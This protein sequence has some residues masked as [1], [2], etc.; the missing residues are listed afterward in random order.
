[1][2]PRENENLWPPFRA[3]G[4]ILCVLTLFLWFCFYQ[5]EPRGDARSRE[6]CRPALP[7]LSLGPPLGET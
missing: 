1:M 7:R 4:T 5:V 6:G 2:V 3:P